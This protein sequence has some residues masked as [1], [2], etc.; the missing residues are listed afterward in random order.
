MTVG[1]GL[2]SQQQASKQPSWKVLRDTC[3][4]CN[5]LE[6]KAIPCHIVHWVTPSHVS[7]VTYSHQSRSVHQSSQ[8]NTNRSH[9]CCLSR[10]SPRSRSN[11]LRKT[12]KLRRLSCT[13]STLPSTGF[14]EMHEVHTF[15]HCIIQSSSPHIKE[16]CWNAYKHASEYSGS[17]RMSN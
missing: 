17:S 13:H 3:A 11:S 9:C 8:H 15:T 12:S 10:S 6:L 2:V 7:L 1:E 16:M 5:A 14:N 4:A